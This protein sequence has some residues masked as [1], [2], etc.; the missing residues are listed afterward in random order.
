VELNSNELKR[1]ADLISSDTISSDTTL[2][3]AAT[4]PGRGAPE[5]AHFAPT[6]GVEKTAAGSNDSVETKLQSSVNLG[7]KTCEETQVRTGEMPPLKKVK[8]NKHKSTNQPASAKGS[9]IKL[10]A[11]TVTGMAIGT[12]GTIIGLAA[13]PP[14]YF[15]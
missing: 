8:G 12:V 6:T 3:E 5:H 2:E 7:S 1:K 13:L 4:V 9:F 14:D 11:A 15:I 10:A